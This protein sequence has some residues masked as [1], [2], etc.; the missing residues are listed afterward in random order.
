MLNSG[1]LNVCAQTLSPYYS[2]F[3]N[4]VRKSFLKGEVSGFLGL[5]FC[6][7]ATGPRKAGCHAVK[8]GL[9]AC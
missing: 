9:E 4:I 2:F 6:F 3:T 8:D 5:D 7:A 1:Y